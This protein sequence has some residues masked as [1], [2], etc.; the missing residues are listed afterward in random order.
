MRLICPNCDAQYEVPAEAVPTEGRDVQCSNCGQTWFQH[1]P[2]HAPSIKEQAATEAIN[3]NEENIGV[4]THPQGKKIDPVVAEILRQEA[5]YEVKIRNKE[6][7]ELKSP[8]DLKYRDN[9]EDVGP[10]RASEAHERMARIR[11]EKIKANTSAVD[12]GS[13]R[14]R[15]P[16]IEAINSTLRSSNDRKFSLNESNSTTNNKKRG[17]KT[18]FITVA[19]IALN[20]AAIYIFAPNIA[21]TVPQVDPFL[22]NYVL[23]IDQ[24]RT[25]L[26]DQLQGLA[27]WLDA[28]AASQ[29]Q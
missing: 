11:G 5:E 17:F 24:C 25:W 3:D 14:D 18:G 12:M 27:K 26:D 2:D 9:V 19:F 21:K 1:H 22:S 13:R 7:A 8:Q 20:L 16:D 15:L 29:K 10:R 4:P 23:V 28:K 6:N